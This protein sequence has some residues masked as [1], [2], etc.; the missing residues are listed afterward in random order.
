VAVF[1]SGCGLS[2]FRGH[3]QFRVKDADHVPIQEFFKNGALAPS[4]HGH[5]YLSRP[6]WRRPSSPATCI[7][8]WRVLPLGSPF[9]AWSSAAPPYRRGGQYLMTG[10]AL[11]SCTPPQLVDLGPPSACLTLVALFLPSPAPGTGTVLASFLLHLGYN[12]MIPSLL[13]FTNVFTHIS[14][15]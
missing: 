15:H 13:T 11:A 8:S 14:G 10:R 9:F 5:A 12:S 6:L 3:R 7:R 1:L 2:I 4:P